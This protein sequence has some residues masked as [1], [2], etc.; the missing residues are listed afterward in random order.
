M[1][2]VVIGSSP[3][4]GRRKFTVSGHSGY[5]PEGSDI[6]CAAVSVLGQT[7]IAALMSLTGLE[8]IYRID[9]EK[10]YL[11]CEVSLPEDPDDRRHIAADA[12]L[13]AFAIGCRQTEAS[14]GTKYVKV[15]KEV[16]R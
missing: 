10:P 9:G 14:Y 12:I 3:D 1:I 11:S 4:G 16:I 6:V 15:E 8:V 2:R 5:A 7:A 13:D